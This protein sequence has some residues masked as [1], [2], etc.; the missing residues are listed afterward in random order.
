[1]PV[2]PIKLPFEDD[3]L[4]PALSKNTLSVHYGK[5]YLGYVQKVNDLN[6]KKYPI[7]SI[8]QYGK[9]LDETLYKNTCQVVNH[10]FYWNCLCPYKKCTIDSVVQKVLNTKFS[11]FNTFKEKFQDTCTS[12]MGSGWV[13][14][15]LDS[16]DK[17]Y[18]KLVSTKDH[19]TLVDHS[20]FIPILVCDVWEHAYYLDYANERNKYVSEF[21]NVVNWDFVRT[22]IV[23]TVVK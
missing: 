1:M 18:P 23:D 9:S 4:A 19:V 13:W 6:T 20:R 14:L 3:S 12:I 15:V 22:R 7:K 8:L 17:F 16:E 2:S 11:N 10:E 5:H 21:F